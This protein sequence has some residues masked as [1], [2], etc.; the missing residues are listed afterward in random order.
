MHHM[1]TN[2]EKKINAPKKGFIKELAAAAE[3][4]RNTVSRALY[5]NSGGRKSERVRELYRNR[6]EK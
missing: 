3:C 6:Y 5:N 1:A 4:G 2:V